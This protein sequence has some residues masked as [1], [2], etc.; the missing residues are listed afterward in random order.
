M[1]RKFFKKIFFL[2]EIF[3]GFYVKLLIVRNFLKKILF[4]V[5]FKFYFYIVIFFI[6]KMKNGLVLCIGI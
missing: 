4:V 2:F 5:L 3:I 1:L 6:I